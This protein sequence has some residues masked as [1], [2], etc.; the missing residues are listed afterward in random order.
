MMEKSYE[1]PVE[2]AISTLKELQYCKLLT[3]RERAAVK[4]ALVFLCDYAGIEHMY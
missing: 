3:A 4:Y 1:N 2:A